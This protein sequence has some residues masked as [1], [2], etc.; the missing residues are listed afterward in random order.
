MLV[1]IKIFEAI[2]RT[3]VSYRWQLRPNSIRRNGVYP[4]VQ[5]KDRTFWARC[6][7]ML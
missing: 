7:S 2:R 3:V 1:L 5:S 6:K 4:C